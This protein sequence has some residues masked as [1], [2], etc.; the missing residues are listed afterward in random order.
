MRAVADDFIRQ[1]A[2]N[3]YA[4]LEAIIERAAS[5]AGKAAQNGVH[6]TVVLTSAAPASE[7]EV[8]RFQEQL[9]ANQRKVD[10]ARRKAAERLTTPREHRFAQDIA[11]MFREACWIER[12]GQFPN[13]GSLNEQRGEVLGMW[14][15]FLAAIDMVR[16]GGEATPEQFLARLEAE[17]AKNAKLEEADA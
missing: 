14:E 4:G 16:Y 8:R 2:L 17:D 11:R 12:I 7:E 13:G 3:P 9:V 5:A 6:E 1:K 10:A 15:A